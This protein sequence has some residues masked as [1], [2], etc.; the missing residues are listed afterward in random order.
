MTEKIAYQG[1]MFEVVNFD[2]EHEPGKVETFEKARRAPGTRLII[3]TAKGLLLTKE[4]RHELNATD[5]RLPGGKVFDSWDEYHDFLAGNKDILIPAIAKAKAEAKEEAGIE[6]DDV[7]HVHTSRLG[8]TVEWDLYYFVVGEHNR[9]EQDLGLGEKIDVVE[10][11][12]D[13]AE[14]MCLDGRISEER[15]ALVLLRFLKD[16]LSNG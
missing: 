5:F 12:R 13:E 8:A 4:F 14:A 7:T 10:V 3:P 11:T 2:V 15:S 1:R 16:E 9:G 6:T